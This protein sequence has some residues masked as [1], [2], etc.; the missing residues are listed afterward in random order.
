[1]VLGVRW[2][3]LFA[4]LEGQLEEAERLEWEAEIV[5]RTQREQALVRLGD[6]VRAATGCLVEV[7][8]AGAGV[9]VGEV[10]A[11]GADWLV[12]SGAGH[13]ETLAAFGALLS[14]AG[15]PERGVAKE[16][17]VTARLGLGY[18]IRAMMRERTELVAVLVDGQ[19]VGGTVGCVGSDYFD[20]VAR[21]EGELAARNGRV[22]TSIEFGGL[23]ALM[24][25]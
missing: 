18:A 3:R 21:S 12:L 7:R 6:R 16:S 22:R 11:V 23:A 17:A 8:L 5:D 1:M 2:Q 20:I 14:V 4:D 10:S 15:L 9:V 13:L 19:R 24:R 25:R